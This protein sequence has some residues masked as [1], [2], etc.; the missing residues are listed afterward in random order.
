MRLTGSHQRLL[1]DLAAVGASYPLALSG[2]HAMGAHDL[3]D[4]PCREVELATDS[5]VPMEDIAA[6]VR[7]GLT[8]RG[9]RVSGADTVPLGARLLLTDA[10]TEEEHTVVL[11]KETVW[12][13]P[14]RTEY[15]LVLAAED[16]VGTRVRALADRGLA[17]DLVDVRAASARWPLLELEEFGRRHASDTFDPADLQ[18]RLEAADWIDDGEF[19]AYGLDAAATE[20]LRRWAH[21]WATEIAERIAEETPYE[22]EDGVGGGDGDDGGDVSGD[23]GGNG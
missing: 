20:E 14:A 11:L 13:P 16:V 5:P 22:D 1:A 4:R 12:R 7:S 3:V 8:E 15:G 17:P 19:A 2:G 21:G 6:V 9:W 10:T 23:D 18:A